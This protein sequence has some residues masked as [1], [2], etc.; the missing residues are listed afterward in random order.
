MLNGNG[1]RFF[2]CIVLTLLVMGSFA[3]LPALAQSKA[4]V[5]SVDSLNAVIKEVQRIRDQVQ[6]S[7][8]ALQALTSGQAADLAKNYKAFAKYVDGA[9]K[10]QATAQKRAEEL[11]ANREEYLQE[12]QKKLE[13]VNNP[14]V[15]AHM[16]ERKAQVAKVFE[17]VQPSAQAVR[18]AFPAYMSDLKDIQQMLSVDL[19]QSGVAAAA[20]IATKAVGN[21]TTVINNLD[22]LLSN[23]TQIRDQVSTK[24]VKS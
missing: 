20:P 19:S 16:E 14:D 9:A 4:S 15:R 8:D 3:E 10:N 2:A 23:L 22:T 11:K 17:S 6:G 18:E 24:V 1:K 12:W 5:K 21:G 7:M 13:A